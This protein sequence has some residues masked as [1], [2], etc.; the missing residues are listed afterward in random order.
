LVFEGRVNLFISPPLFEEYEKIL[1]RPK[2]GLVV[3]DVRELLSII[4]AKALMVEPM[5]K[6]GR[7]KSDEQDNRILECALECR[8]DFI[9][10][11]S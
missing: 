2:F 11:S 8:A 9:T 1:L 7:I 6:V 5:K 4:K 10:P 3:S